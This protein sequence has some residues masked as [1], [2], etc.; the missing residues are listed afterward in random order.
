MM[1]RTPRHDILSF[2]LSFSQSTI[3]LKNADETLVL[4]SSERVVTKAAAAL[5]LTKFQLRRPSR[6]VSLSQLPLLS[7]PYTIGCETLRT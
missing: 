3:Y 5:H 4:C 1:K 7:P 6:D 2:F